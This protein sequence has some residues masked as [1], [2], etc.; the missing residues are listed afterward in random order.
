M[1][2]RFFDWLDARQGQW[3]FAVGYPW[4]VVLYKFPFPDDGRV[5]AGFAC[6]TELLTETDRDS[7]TSEHGDGLTQV[8]TAVGASAIETPAKQGENLIRQG[9]QSGEIGIRTRDAGFPTYRISNPALSA[10]QPSLQSESSAQLP[11]GTRP[12][13][14]I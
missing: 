7:R 1:R 4:G 5:A 6:L 12:T 8:T 11:E 2:F 3:K 14:R 13:S 10:T 9:P